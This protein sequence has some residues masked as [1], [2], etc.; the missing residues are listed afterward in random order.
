MATG[1]TGAEVEAIAASSIVVRSAPV[2]RGE[3]GGGA[4]PR[5]QRNTR[6]EGGLQTCS[7]DEQQGEEEF[8]NFKRAQKH[9][10]R[11]HPG[12]ARAQKKRGGLRT[13]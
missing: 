7:A 10:L 1:G 3:F 6:K 13:N 5:A 11:T 8:A 9:V 2:R 4:P 12:D